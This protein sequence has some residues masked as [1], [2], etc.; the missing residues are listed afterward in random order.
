MSTNN[1]LFI[2]AS[3]K[4]YRF[5]SLKGQLL[6]ED[7]FDLSLASLDT[8]AVDLDEKVQKAGRKSFVGKRATATGDDENKLEIVKA[9]IEIK[10]TEDENRKTRVVKD[11]QKAFLTSLL[12]KKQMEKMESLSEEEIQKQ[13]ASL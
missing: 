1:E 5:T 2:T 6:T 4:K 13:L 3:R 10:Q 9:V 8:I 7:L 11:G 12:E